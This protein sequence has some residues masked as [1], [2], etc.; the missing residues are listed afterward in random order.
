MIEQTGRTE[1]TA[2]TIIVKPFD[3]SRQAQIAVI[4]F[5][6]IDSGISEAL[7]GGS[8]SEPTISSSGQTTNIEEAENQ[9]TEETP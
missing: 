2:G 7:L 8:A 9:S 4:K 6:V 3:A 1:F 5:A